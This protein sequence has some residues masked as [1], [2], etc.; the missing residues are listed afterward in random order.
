MRVGR[1][2]QRNLRYRLGGGDYIPLRVHSHYSFLDS[3]LS[4]AAIV[5]LAEQ[6]GMAAVALTDTGNLH[7]AVE[8]MLAAKQ[9]GIKPVLGVEFSLE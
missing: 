3:T 7:G 2:T 1:V 5:E 4:P 9:A 8:F 6:H